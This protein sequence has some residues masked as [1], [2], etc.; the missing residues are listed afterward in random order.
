M[1]HTPKGDLQHVYD[2]DDGIFTSWD[3]RRPIETL[4][5][6]DRMLSVPYKFTPPPAEQFEAV[7]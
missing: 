6:V 1:L 3:I 7:P 2:A 5:D 4:E